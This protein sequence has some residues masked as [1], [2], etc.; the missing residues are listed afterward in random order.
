VGQVFEL[1]ANPPEF[2][3]YDL[4]SDP[5]ELIELSSKPEHAETLKRLQT[6]LSDWQKATRDPLIT[7]EGMAQM[8][9]MEKPMTHLNPPPKKQGGKGKAGAKK[10]TA[11]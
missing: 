3:L 6:A 5:W 4:Q 10:S 7:P 9:V 11:Q 1:A 8:K 2:E